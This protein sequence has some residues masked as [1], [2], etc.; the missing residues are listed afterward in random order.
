[1]AGNLNIGT[2]L[3]IVK[4]IFAIHKTE[5][6]KRHT[7]RADRIPDTDKGNIAAGVR[8][9]AAKFN[10]GF[11]V[12]PKGFARLFVVGKGTF[13]QSGIGALENTAVIN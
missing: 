11:T 9:L 13:N 4:F 3:G 6:R 1:M 10:R 5:K 12:G 8:V 2:H 7:Q